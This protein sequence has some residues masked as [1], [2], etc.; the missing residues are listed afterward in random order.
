[1][2]LTCKKPKH[3]PPHPQVKMNRKNSFHLHS[4][5]SVSKDFIVKVKQKKLIKTVVNLQLKNSTSCA[6]VIIFR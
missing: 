5:K 1:M 6:F 3:H 2:I 4:A